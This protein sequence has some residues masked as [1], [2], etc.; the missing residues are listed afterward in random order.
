MLSDV[1]MSN[2]N[3]FVL[4]LHVNM[5][6]LSTGV[7]TFHGPFLVTDNGYISAWLGCLSAMNLMLTEMKDASPERP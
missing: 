6:F 2:P 3:T 1:S 7:T 4:K 5:R